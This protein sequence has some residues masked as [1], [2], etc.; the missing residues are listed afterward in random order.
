MRLLWHILLVNYLIDGLEPRF[1]AWGAA[2][3]RT[4]AGGIEGRGLGGEGRGGGDNSRHLGAVAY[5][6]REG[7]GRDVS[8]ALNMTGE[9]ATGRGQR[10]RLQ[11]ASDKQPPP[12]RG[13]L[14]KAGGARRRCFDCAQHDGQGD[15]KSPPG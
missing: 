1:P 4:G 9:G 14:Q 5:S 12:Q 6:G 7:R 2:E 8:T 10:P 15:K 11:R 3:R 13:G